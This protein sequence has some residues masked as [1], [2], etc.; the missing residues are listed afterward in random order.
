MPVKCGLIGGEVY[1]LKAEFD[2][3]REWAAELG[4]PVQVVLHFIE[5]AGWRQVCGSRKVP[6]DR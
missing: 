3:A 5:E 4:M 2:P 6:G 1:T